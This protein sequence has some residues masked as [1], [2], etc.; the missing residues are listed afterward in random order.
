M[1]QVIKP[2]IQSFDSVEGGWKCKACGQ[3]CSTEDECYEH[4]REQKAKRNQR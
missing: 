4:L 1:K 3:I 2:K